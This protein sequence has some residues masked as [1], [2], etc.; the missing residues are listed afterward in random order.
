M[1]NSVC[2][3]TVVLSRILIVKYYRLFRGKKSYISLPIFL[4]LTNE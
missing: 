3:C 1:A 2:P 4:G